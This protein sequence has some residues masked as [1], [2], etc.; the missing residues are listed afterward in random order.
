MDTIKEIVIDALILLAGLIIVSAEGVASKAKGVSC[1][2][3][4]IEAPA[5]T[6]KP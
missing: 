3:A 4:G 1:G 2:P 6:G 5:Q